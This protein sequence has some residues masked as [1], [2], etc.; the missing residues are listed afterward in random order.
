MPAPPTL[1]TIAP[2]LVLAIAEHLPLHGLQA[3]VRCNRLLYHLLLRFLYQR[4]IAA[5]Q[6]FNCRYTDCFLRDENAWKGRPWMGNPRQVTLCLAAG[7]DVNTIVFCHDAYTRLHLAALNKWNHRWPGRESRERYAEEEEEVMRLLL[8]HGADANTASNGGASPLHLVG[9][10]ND[11]KMVALLLDHGADVNKA[12]GKSMSPLNYAVRDS[13][14]L[15]TIGI[16]LEHGADPNNVDSEGRSPLHFA[17]RYS[18]RCESPDVVVLLLEHGADPNKVDKRLEAP[19][20]YTYGVGVEEVAHLLKYGANPN[21]ADEKGKT[22]LHHALGGIVWEPELAVLLLDHG[23]D[24]NL[25]DGNGRSPL[26]YAVMR[27]SCKM[28]ACLL[29]HGANPNLWKGRPWSPLQDA[30]HRLKTYKTHTSHDKWQDTKR[31]LSDIVKLL[32][33]AGARVER[34]EK[35][36]RGLVKTICARQTQPTPAFPPAERSEPTPNNT[37]SLPQIAST[38]SVTS[39]PAQLPPTS[40]PP[41][42]EMEEGWTKVERRKGKGKGKWKMKKVEHRPAVGGPT[43]ADIARGGG[44]SV[45]VFVG[46]GAGYSKPNTC[47]S[48]RSSKGNSAL[49]RR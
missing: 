46:R 43:W 15:T 30:L 49:L 17:V 3:L 23:A 36:K 32:V 2:E 12:D 16:L 22:R 10:E 28:V 35:T 31:S 26:N 4:A 29:E 47:Q 8:A 33:T 21:K 5:R 14:G 44:A 48:G 25:A 7:L 20:H 42:D 27:H 39:G 37:I 38:K 41:R 34:L 9:R 1:I 18:K 45:N 11:I 40:E 6:T 13:W 24:A 19:L